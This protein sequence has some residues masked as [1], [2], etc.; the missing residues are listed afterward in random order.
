MK[1]IDVD[2]VRRLLCDATCA[3]I[4]V[5][6][7]AGSLVID[8]PHILQ[9]GRLLQVFIRRDEAGAV[10]VDEG[11]FAAAE[12]ELHIR[13]SRVLRKRHAEIREICES[14]YLEF[15]SGRIRYTAAD[16]SSAIVRIAVLALAV[17]RVLGLGGR[18]FLES[19][20]LASRS[21]LSDELRERGLKVTP[22]RRI[23]LQ[24]N[25]TVTVDFEITGT[26]HRQALVEFLAGTDIAH[27]TAAVD[28]AIV[29]LRLLQNDG[30]QAKLFG[31]YEEHSAAAGERMQAR[32]NDAIGGAAVLLSSS[33]APHR[34]HQELTAA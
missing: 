22:R 14:L 17:D 28:R 3:R 29:N 11:G 1:S 26:G 16:V 7:D 21:G 12:A 19:P 27:A 24:T 8:T 33:D 23:E 5:E 30:H 13:S 31:V 2:E 9:D 34:I 4:R 15:S 10:L 6:P 18:R 20:W 25:G 32:F